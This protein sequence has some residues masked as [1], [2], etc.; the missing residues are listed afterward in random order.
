ML[1][2]TLYK[3]IYKIPKLYYGVL[4]PIAPVMST[5]RLAEAEE[6]DHVSFHKYCVSFLQREFKRQI[7]ININVG[8]AYKAYSLSY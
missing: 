3:I 7:S 1:R 6:I 8:I 4:L 5:S 2:H